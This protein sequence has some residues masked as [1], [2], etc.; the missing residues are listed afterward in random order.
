MKKACN[1][2]NPARLEN[3]EIFYILNIV[4]RTVTSRP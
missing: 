1:H 3:Q 2:D 4:L